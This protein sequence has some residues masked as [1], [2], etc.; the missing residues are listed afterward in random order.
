VR[1]MGKTFLDHHS[2]LTSQN[3]VDLFNRKCTIP[4]DRINASIDEQQRD[5]GLHKVS[6]FGNA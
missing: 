1:M 3:L 2:Y 6:E 4:I 5:I